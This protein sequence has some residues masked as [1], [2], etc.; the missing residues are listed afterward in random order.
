MG[1]KAREKVLDC[2]TIDRMISD[3]QRVMIEALNERCGAKA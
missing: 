2:Y 1:K 3:T